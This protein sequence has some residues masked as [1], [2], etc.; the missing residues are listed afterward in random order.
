MRES[1]EREADSERMWRKKSE[2]VCYFMWW[3]KKIFKEVLK[4]KQELYQK[5]SEEGWKY[6]EHILRV[7]KC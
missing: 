5:V 4:V 2:L 7:L 3:C 6:E 1:E